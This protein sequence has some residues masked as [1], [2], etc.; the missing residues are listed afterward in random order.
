M[1]DKTNKELHSEIKAL[2][3]ALDKRDQE[4]LDLHGLYKASYKK[5]ID[6]LKADS[7]ILDELIGSV[8]ALEGVSD[9]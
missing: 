5:L 9:A 3:E 7:I 8:D 1:T 2:K 6:D 4:V